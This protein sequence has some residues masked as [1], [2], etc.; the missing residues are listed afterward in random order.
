MLQQLDAELREDVALDPSEGAPAARPT[1]DGRDRAAA[2]RRREGA[3]AQAI[4]LND[5]LRRIVLDGDDWAQTEVVVPARVLSGIKSRSPLGA[6]VVPAALTR[7]A[8]QPERPPGQRRGG[9]QTSAPKLKAELATADSVDLICAFVT[10]TGV[11]NLRESLEDV[12]RRGG[13]CEV[14]EFHE[15]HAGLSRWSR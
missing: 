12:V 6:P 15:H 2:R 9:S 7:D 10:W 11:R 8:V 14:I 3:G 4:R 13:A 5:L 1:C